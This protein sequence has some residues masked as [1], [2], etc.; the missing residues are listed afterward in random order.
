MFPVGP[1]SQVFSSYGGHYGPVF[2]AHFL[3]QNAAIAA[4]TITGIH[5][6]LHVL[7]IGNGLT[8]CTHE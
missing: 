1:I 2:A 4:G 7:G 8:V 6:N 3:S 5:L